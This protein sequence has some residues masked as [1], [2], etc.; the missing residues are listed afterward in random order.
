MAFWAQKKRD[1]PAPSLTFCANSN[2]PETSWTP[3][4]S[5]CI[6]RLYKKRKG[7]PSMLK[8]LTALLLSLL[9]CLPLLPGQAH[10][11]DVPSSD[12]SPVIVESLAPE[13]PG[14]PEPPVMPLCEEDVPLKD[15]DHHT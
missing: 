1:A 3:M 9:M 2:L 7:D 5:W 12:N 10:A 11:A 8:K 4:H 15:D 13:T 14:N 6:L